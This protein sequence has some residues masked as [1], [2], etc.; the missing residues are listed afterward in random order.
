M[1]ESTH[2]QRVPSQKSRAWTSCPAALLTSWGILFKL[3]LWALVFS[4]EN[5]N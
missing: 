1:G 3:C 5:G 2:L 4:V